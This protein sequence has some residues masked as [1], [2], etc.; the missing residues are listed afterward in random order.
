MAYFKCPYPPIVHLLIFDK[1][2][3]TEHSMQQW[4]HRNGFDASFIRENSQ[5]FRAEQYPKEEFVPGSFRTRTV[6]G[7]GRVRAITGC[8]F[9]ALHGRRRHPNR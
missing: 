1:R 8:P 4:L 3:H 2:W 7:P 5:S 6:A 9:A